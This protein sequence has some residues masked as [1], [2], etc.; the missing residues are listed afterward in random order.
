MQSCQEHPNVGIWLYCSVHY[1]E[2]EGAPFHVIFMVKWSKNDLNQQMRRH[3][4]AEPTLMRVAR[5]LSLVT[6][7]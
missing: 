6:H 4:G 3:K 1:W 7:K 5:A 2:H